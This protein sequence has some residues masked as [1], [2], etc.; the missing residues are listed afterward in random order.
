MPAWHVMVADERVAALNRVRDVRMLRAAPSCK[1]V[2]IARVDV[3]GKVYA[4]RTP[5]PW[6]RGCCAN[7]E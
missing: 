5:Q 3:T 4:L 1:N 2:V 6:W 7:V